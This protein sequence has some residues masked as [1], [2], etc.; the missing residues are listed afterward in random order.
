MGLDVYRVT[1]YD[2][3]DRNEKGHYVGTEDEGS[4]HGP[5]EAAYLASVAA[6]AEEAPVKNPT[7]APL[8]G[9]EGQR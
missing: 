6:F 8:P 1:K 3:A 5:V 7:P 2:P 4:D 9:G